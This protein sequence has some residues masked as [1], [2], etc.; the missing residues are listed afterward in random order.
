VGLVLGGGGA[1]GA[2]HIGVLEVLERLRVPVDC[3]AGTS[4]GALV[5]GGYAGGLTAAQMRA[6][7]ARA[8]WRDMFQDEPEFSERGFRSKNIAQRFLPGLEMGVGA[9]GVQVLP[10]VLGGQKIKLF[11]NRLVRSDMGEREIESL[12]LPVSLIATDIATGERVVYRDGSLTAAM[13]AS[14]S[15]PGLMAPIEHRGRKLVDGGLVDNV[16]IRE[17]RER[18]GA[19]VV[20]AVNVGS[21]LLKPAD[22]GSLLSVSAQM[23]NILTE[24]NVTQSLATLGPRDIYIKPD[25]TG[26][27]AGDFE[28]HAETADRG[29]QAA[30]AA[31]DRL[32]ALSVSESEYAAW[33]GRVEFAKREAPRIDEVEVAG[34][35]RVNPDAVERHLAGLEGGRTDSAGLERGIGRVY[36]DGWYQ[37]VDYTLLRQRDRNILRIA[38]VEKSWGP[39]Y[40]RFGFNLDNS[41][42]DYTSYSLRTAY[43]MTWLNRLG[44]ELMVIGDIGNNPQIGFDFYQP[45]DGAQRFFI[46]PGVRYGRRQANLYQNNQRI[47][48]Y[49]VDETRLAL[50]VGTNIGVLGQAR[51]GW[52]ERSEQATLDTGTLVL[53]TE[54]KR[55]GGWQASLDIDQFD[56]LYFPTRGWATQLAYFDSPDENYAKLRAELRG[57]MSLGNTVVN[58]RLAYGGSPRGVLPGFDAVSIGGFGN[59]SGFKRGQILADQ[60]SYAGL[61]FEQIIGRLPLGLRGD[62]RAGIGLEA[63]H[64]KGNYTEAQLGSPLY[65]VALYLGGETPLGPVYLGW[66][67]SP[68]GVGTV[69]LFV[70]TP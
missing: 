64:V 45:L 59:L 65:S 5:S 43:H 70:G 54:S 29:R 46:E 47:A 32:R 18:C 4:M 9:G 61:R 41:V 68:K 17:V 1:R 6:E 27:T 38:P 42:G 53:P 25:L 22:I 19:Q 3:V 49:N 66:G 12:P 11:F 60:V 7:M 69:Q 16:P 21:P 28:R 56:T 35:K 50:A 39:N 15:V 20:I 24:Q 57:A 52:L 33:W 30:E 36:G 44:A 26:I 55:F 48:A 62:M 2:A 37:S 10:G 34:L 13:R 51:I 23:I 14:M 67:W 31:A 58:G 63:A 40:L 8:D